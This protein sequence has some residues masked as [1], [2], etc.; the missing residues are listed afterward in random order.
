MYV[1]AFDRQ[2]I[3]RALSGKPDKVG[4]AVKDNPGVDGDKL[5]KDAFNQAAHGG[6]WVDYIFKNPQ[7]GSV[8]L[9]TSYV[10]PA[11]A[12]LILGCGVYKSRE[13]SNKTL[14]KGIGPGALRREQE[15]QLGM[16]PAPAA[17][18]PTGVLTP[19]AG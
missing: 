13:M 8:D 14:L 3:Y 12:D 1:F 2:G 18:R 4:T 17:A 9:K 19:Q 6:G 5:V 10:L 15:T 11:S 16:G 7:T